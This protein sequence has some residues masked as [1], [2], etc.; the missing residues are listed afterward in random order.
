MNGDQILQELNQLDLSYADIAKAMNISRVTVSLVANRKGHSRRI[1][2][3]LAIALDKPVEEVF[4]DRPKY[5][6][7]PDPAQRLR[8]LAAVRDA[9][10]AA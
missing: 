6:H 2:R 10:D 1:A 4:P 8:L 7:R 9:A 3:A 5:H